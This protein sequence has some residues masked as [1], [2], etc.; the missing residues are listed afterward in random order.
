MQILY[1]WHLRHSGGDK[2]IKAADRTRINEWF[3]PRFGPDRFRAFV[4][5]LFLP[6]T[7]MCISFA[8]IG[9]LLA[10]QVYWDRVAAIAL[11]YA[12]ALGMGA[13]AADSIGSKKAK[14][15]G[16]YFTKKKVVML[17]ASSLAVAYGIGA[18]YIIAYAPLLAIV[19]ALEGFFLFA[20][21]L[22]LFGGL[23][24]NDLWFAISWGALPVMAGYLIQASEP[25]P[26]VLVATAAATMA[27]YAEI[28]LSRPYKQMRRSGAPAKALERRLK[29]LS[30][31]TIIFSIC[32]LVARV[33]MS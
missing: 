14:P 4:G 9:S 27:G 1:L 11:I 23:F 5:M 21:N 32:V 29:I 26:L 6:Y 16:E 28:R 3:V 13:H 2:A 12:L 33:T 10:P 17:M 15:W 31:S 30:M 8:I 24:H 22:E 7:G 20:Y 25:G 19:A 18:Y